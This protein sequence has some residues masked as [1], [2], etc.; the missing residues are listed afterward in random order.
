MNG[1]ELNSKYL[2]YNYDKPSSFAFH[3]LVAGFFVKR[4]LH[5]R[6]DKLSSHLFFR[7]FRLGF[8]G[9]ML[10]KAGEVY[11]E[12]DEHDA[13]HEIIAALF[14]SYLVLARSVYD[15]LLIFLKEQYGV[16]EGSYNDFLKKLKKGNYENIDQKFRKHLSN[17][18]FND[19]RSLRD[20][21]V[22]K[23]PTLMVYVK[24]NSYYVEGTMYR[25]DG[26]RE[27]VDKPLYELIFSYTVSLLLLMAYI[28]EK[29]TGLSFSEQ[30][31]EI[32]T[33]DGL[34]PSQVEKG[35]F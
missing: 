30:F 33:E 15:Y 11:V 14:E 3:A 12:N 29:E 13:N 21:V 35:Q 2:K 27:E 9:D 28:S 5:K 16:Q 7:L 10:F 19:L 34:V 6:K 22:H 4:I 20:S 8:I 31:N 25:D 32:Q 26:T 24:D 17:T 18:I 23:T 1:I